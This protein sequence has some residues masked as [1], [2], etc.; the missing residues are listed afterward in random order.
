MFLWLPWLSEAVLIIRIIAVFK[1]RPRRV[2]ATVL[3]VPITMKLFRAALF[4][5]YLHKWWEDSAKPGAISANTR[6]IASQSWI[7]QAMCVSELVDD[8]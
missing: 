7:Q 4:I 3:V 5:Y 8:A 1:S 2:L 6:A